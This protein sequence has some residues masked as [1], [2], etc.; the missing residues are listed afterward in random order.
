MEFSGYI[1]EM[2][3]DMEGETSPKCVVPQVKGNILQKVIDFCQYHEQHK[4]VD[5]NNEDKFLEVTKWNQEFVRIEQAE[6]F[7]LILAANFMN[8]KNLLEL[9][10]QSVA[11]MIKG[12][13]PEQIRSTFGITNDFTEQE[14]AEVKR[15]NQWAFE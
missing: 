14:E 9:C 13:S 8:I 6:L 10:C 2:L 1:T 11:N 5:V 15:E 7:E 3:E 4:D 12:K